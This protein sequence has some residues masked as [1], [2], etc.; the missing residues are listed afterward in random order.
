MSAV[1]A[2]SD[3]HGH[4][5]ELTAALHQAGLVDDDVRWSGADAR[6][7]VLGDLLDRG[8]DGLGVIALVRRLADEAAAAG[9]AVRTL[10]G[11]HEVIALGTRRFGDTEVV[12]R[13]VVRT[14]SSIWAR[15][16][17][18]ES[19]QAGIDDELFAWMAA[20]PAV[21]R[22]G[23]HLLMHSDTVG[24]LEWGSSVDAVNATVR[25]V[26]AGDD[27][28]AWFD[29]LVGLGQ[30]HEY[31]GA[32]GT[33]VARRVLDTLGGERIVHGHSIIGDLFDEPCDSY[34]EPRLYA[35]GLAL[36]IDGGIYEG[37]PC[38]VARLSGDD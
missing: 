20:L 25:E 26:L 15:N 2:T 37:G 31:A 28:V 30:R 16:G 11:N 8:P 22:D 7:W 17:G 38:L 12:H 23:A 9:G 34:S 1:F 18:L 10:L 24:Y 6:L 5:A 3:A 32:A 14:F 29:V 21:G 35:D 4:L 19:D 13:G 33:A 27:P 36:D